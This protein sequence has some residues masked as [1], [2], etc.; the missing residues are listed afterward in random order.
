LT[1]G[2]AWRWLAR[3]TPPV[4]V[5]HVTHHK[6]GSQ[7]IRRILEELAQPW[8]VEPRPDGNQF[9][10]KPLRPHRVYPTL[11]LTRDQFERVRVPAGSRRFIV[12]RDLR[13]TLI[14]AYF[15][16]KISHSPLDPQMVQYRS[17]LVGLKQADALLRM[18][19]QVCTPMATIQR[20]WLNGPD[21]LIKYEDLL[22]HEGE[23]FPRLL[24]EHCQLPLGRQALA[25]I[26]AANRF[27]A[28]TGG[29]KPGAEE[30]RSHERKGI[31]GDWKNHFTDKVAK[32]FRETY[33]DLL[34]ATGYEQ[35]D[36]W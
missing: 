15:S 27:E 8:V 20:S 4:S 24:I 26:V 31:A 18:I 17:L 2:R 35:D 9:L 13:D 6:A 29:R 28:R 30:R 12:I 21:E 1:L 7:W 25:K 34:I 19:R 14:S 36:R 32:A 33:G 22:D 23:L 3:P 5:F 10:S 11:Y 16:L